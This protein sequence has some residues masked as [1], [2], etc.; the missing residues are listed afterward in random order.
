MHYCASFIGVFH[1]LICWRAFA[2]ANIYFNVDD[3]FVLFQ[4]NVKKS[5]S[6]GLHER[7]WRSLK[8]S[9]KSNCGGV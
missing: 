2:K 3:L 5:G 7:L 9:Q 8:S 1:W 6:S 4:P